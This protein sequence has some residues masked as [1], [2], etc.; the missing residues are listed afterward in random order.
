MRRG[1]RWLVSILLVLSAAACTSGSGSSGTQ[2]AAAGASIEKAIVIEAPN[3]SEG[4]SAEYKWIRDNLP[5]WQTGNQYLLHQNGR[6]YDVINV[7]R[8]G[9]TRAVYFDITA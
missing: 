7:S 9:E 5:G 1:S 4:V 8:G 3:E 2:P 6:I